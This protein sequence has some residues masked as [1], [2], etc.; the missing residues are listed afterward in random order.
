M[1]NVCNPQPPI[2][3]GFRQQQCI[4]E[5]RIQDVCL[6]QWF[7]ARS[8]R[9]LSFAERA[10]QTLKEALKLATRL[11]HFLFQYRNTPHTM[12]GRS[13]AELLLGRKPRTLL[14]LLHPATEPQSTEVP[15]EVYARVVYGELVEVLKI[16]YD[17]PPVI[18]VERFKFN[19][20]SE[21]I[22]THLRAVATHHQVQF[23]E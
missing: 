16:H 7:Q 18:A 22:A 3:P 8:M 9:G 23:W 6:S 2:T 10:V 19:Q 4:Q 11:A 17:P 14:H 5:P 21:N 20:P 15:Q 1:V 13:P 12:T